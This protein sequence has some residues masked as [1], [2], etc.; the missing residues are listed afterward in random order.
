MAGTHHR[1]VIHEEEDNEDGKYLEKVLSGLKS[2][3]R[4]WLLTIDYLSCRN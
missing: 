4:F 2:D 3:V 1:G